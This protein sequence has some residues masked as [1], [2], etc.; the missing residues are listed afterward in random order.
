MEKAREVIKKAGIPEKDLYD[1]PTS[2]ATF[3]DGAHYR[4]EISGIEEP[5]TLEA[6][7]NEMDKRNISIHRVIAL[8]AGATLFTNSELRDVAQMGHDAQME[9][10][11]VPGPRPTWDI[12]RMVTTELG[13]TSGQK[14]RGSDGLAY[15]VADIYRCLEAGLKGFLIWDEGVIWLLN[16]MRE[17]GDIPKDTVLKVSFGTGHANPAGAKLMEDLGGDSFNPVADLPL[18]AM[19]SLRKAIKIPMDIL[20]FANE[21]MGAFNRFWEA[22]DMVRIC[23]PCYLKLEP[24]PSL[25]WASSKFLADFARTK[26]KYMEIVKELIERIHP[27]LKVSGK[28]PKDLVIP[29][30]K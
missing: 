25:G 30:Y 17:N 27:D 4:L 29:E 8:G 11:V 22:P 28:G 9:V 20:I 14:T 13:S 5:S 19:A 18:P 12:G 7:I 1:L 6:L 26:V 10:I 15:L 24:G 16:K 2:G 21:D 23:S 3:P